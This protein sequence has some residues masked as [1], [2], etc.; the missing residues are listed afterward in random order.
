VR[1]P[2]RI[3]AQNPLAAGNATTGAG[4]HDF[5]FF[6]SSQRRCSA[7]KPEAIG[8]TRGDPMPHPMSPLRAVVSRGHIAFRKRNSEAHSRCVF[9]AACVNRLLIVRLAARRQSIARSCAP[10]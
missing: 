2:H 7:A 9:I 1:I 4:S 3:D 10:D 8:S 6:A 5:V